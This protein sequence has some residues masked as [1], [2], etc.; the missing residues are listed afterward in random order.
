MN[1]LLSILLLFFALNVSGQNFFWSHNKPQTNN[2]VDVKYGYLYNWYAATDARKITSSDDWIVPA[3]TDINTLSTYLGGDAV[4][5]GKLKDTLYWN[6]PNTGATNEAG[7]NFRGGGSR[8]G[9][10][11]GLFGEDI[12]I[13]GIIWTTTL[14]SFPPLGDFPYHCATW[15]VSDDLIISNPFIT[16]GSSIRLLYT[17][18]DI[19][20]SYT[21]NDGKIYNKIVLIGSQYWLAENLSETKYRNGDWITGYDGGVYTPISNSTWAAATTGM[22]CAYNDDESNAINE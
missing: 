19:P 20:T 1:K 16:Q 3:L 9:N 10:G 14:L 11:D 17:G 5:G 4:S 12:R 22:M 15:Y 2:V 6:E 18:E 13:N 8:G 7:F 21:G